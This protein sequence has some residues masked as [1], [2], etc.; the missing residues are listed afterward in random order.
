MVSFLIIQTAS[1][2]DVILTTPLLESLHA[3]FPEAKIDLLVKKGHEVLFEGHPFLRR[4]I[5]WDKSSRK[6]LLLAGLTRTIRSSRYQHVINVQRFGSTGW[7]TACSGARFRSGFN[8]NP[9]SVFFTHRPAH[10]LSADGHPVHEV[11]R[12]LSLISYLEIK[13]LRKPKLYPSLS[14]QATVSGYKKVP[15]L[16][17]APASLWFTKQFP[18]EKWIGFLDAV[19]KDLMVYLTGS[20]Q[21]ESLCESI[22][23]R[24]RH[25]SVISL[26]GKLTLLQTAALMK[27][28]R[29]NFVNDS[30]P[31]HLA[32]AVDAPVSA[33]FCSTVP[34]FGFGP[35]S[36]NSSV[37]ETGEPLKCRPCGLHGHHRCPEEHFQ[38]AL[39]IQINQLLERIPG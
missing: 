14:D 32:S 13:S 28:A 5:P 6:Y 31:Q 3:A 18:A 17:I 20:A 36:E 30:A 29:M 15:Y 23:R 19:P 4:V 25:R 35:L 2:V 27:D 1:I 22:M 9:F 26:A 34:S 10:I 16:C 37:I 11:D 7:I 33:I 8:K 39:T 12:N 21:D 24:T 38:C